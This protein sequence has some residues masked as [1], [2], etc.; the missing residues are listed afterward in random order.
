MK[1]RQ[2]SRYALVA[3][4]CMTLC[5]CITVPNDGAGSSVNPS[6]QYNGNITTGGIG[7]NTVAGVNMGANDY[8]GN[9]Y[10]TNAPQNQTY[11]FAFDSDNIHGA[12]M[13]SIAAQ[14]R[15]LSSHRNARIRLEG[16]TDARGSR[17][18]NVGLGERRADAVAQILEQNGASSKQIYVVSYGEEKPAMSGSSPRAYQ[19]NRRVNL[20]YTVR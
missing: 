5:A 10:S 1:L 13:P 2:L 16:N 14:G 18:Y 12:Y 4:S 20:L 11:Y 7:G 3:A 8:L 9:D 15:Y 19:L 6:Q 17:E